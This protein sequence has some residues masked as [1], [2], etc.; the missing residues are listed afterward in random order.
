MSAPK[1]TALIST[2]ETMSFWD[3]EKMHKGFFQGGKKIDVTSGL[4]DSQQ[5]VSAKS[6]H[7]VWVRHD[8]YGFLSHQSQELWTVDMKDVLKILLRLFEQGFS[9]EVIFSTVLTENTRQ[10]S[11][12]LSR[13]FHTLKTSC[14]QT[15]GSCGFWSFESWNYNSLS[16]VQHNGGEIVSYS[17]QC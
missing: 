4:I 13:K 17:L 8:F 14:A 9:K 2:V 1:P 3:C 11:V 6:N 16:C 5:P 15:F 10:L 12:V 7:G